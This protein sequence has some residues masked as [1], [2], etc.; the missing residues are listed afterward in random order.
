[1][2]DGDHLDHDYY[3]QCTEDESAKFRSIIDSCIWIELYDR[4]LVD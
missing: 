1:M 4:F 2:K 3:P